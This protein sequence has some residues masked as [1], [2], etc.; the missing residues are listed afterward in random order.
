MTPLD[1]SV[2][3]YLNTVSNYPVLTREEEREL[4]QRLEEGDSGARQ[5]LVECN[6]RFVVKIARQYTGQGTPLADLI[7]E[8]NIGLLDV[9][10]RFDW[11]RGYRFSTYAAFWIREAMQ[12]A[13]R[14]Q[15]SLIR[16]PVRKARL[17]GKVAEAIRQLRHEGAHDPTPGQVAGVMG[18]PVEQV[19]E[20]MRLR[21]SV[22]SLDEAR[23]TDGATLQDALPAATAHPAEAIQKKEMCVHVARALENL[24]ERERQ[25]LRL[26]F[27]F[28]GGASLSLR[29]VSRLVGLS[30]EGVRRVE[31]RALEK[32]QRPAM[33]ARIAALA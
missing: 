14:T 8:G 10:E 1:P 29:K 16:I 18:L 2:Q 7:Q 5:R 4:F 12:R 6:L 21:E 17:M 23:D 22:L 31:R 28:R 33:R 20:L 27:G 3:D 25:V 13:V 32:L 9:I 30:Q 15:G 26:R 24:T 11:R 19:E